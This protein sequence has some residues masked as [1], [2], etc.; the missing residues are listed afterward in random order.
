MQGVF[1]SIHIS[2]SKQIQISKFRQINP[3]MSPQESNLTTEESCQVIINSVRSSCLNFSFQETPY[4]MYI[5]VRKSF[6]Q[7]FKSEPKVS[8]E[9]LFSPTIRVVPEHH[10]DSLQAKVTKLETAHQ[11]LRQ[12]FEDSDLELEAATNDNKNL[13]EKIETLHTKLSEAEKDV[14]TIVRNKTRQLPLRKG[15]TS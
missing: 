1:L 4:S 10:Q 13:E 9:V 5:T 15:T 6:L 8:P 12:N 2:R 14:D 7:F 11:I 3:T